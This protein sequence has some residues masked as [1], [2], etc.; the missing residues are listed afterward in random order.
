VSP[1]AGRIDREF[2]AQ[3]ARAREDGCGIEFDLGI[4][5]CLHERLFV[6]A[7]SREAS[8]ESGPLH[9]QRQS[10]RQRLLAVHG[11]PR[12]AGQCVE[13]RTAGPLTLPKDEPHR[14][15]LRIDSVALDFTPR[16]RDENVTA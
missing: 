5:R 7:T 14:A 9:R 4:C 16:L 11:L 13:K 1:G 8:C 12:R 6:T 3:K 10:R 15:A 2:I